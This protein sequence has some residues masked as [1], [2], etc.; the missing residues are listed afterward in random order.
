MDPNTPGQP[1]PDAPPPPPSWASTPPP[2]TPPEWGATPPAVPPAWAT[3]PPAGSGGSGMGGVVGRA[4]GGFLGSVA[5][6]II[7]LV[8]V[9]GILAAG[10]FLVTKIFN[11]DHL[12]Q[13][14]YTTQDPSGTSDCSISGTVTSVKAGTP[15]W[16]V[17]MWTRRLSSTDAVVEEDFLNGVSLGK[18]DIPSDKSSDADCLSVTNDLSSEFS[19]PGSYEIKLTVGTEVVADG[20]LTVTP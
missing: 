9:I 4:G 15:V 11:P 17:Y 6:R 5:G 16:S 19:A 7:A 12:G 20:K 1:T 3:T 14:I 13:V 2:A 10:G 8:V 18:Y